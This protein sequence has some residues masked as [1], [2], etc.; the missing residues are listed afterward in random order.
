MREL[1]NQSY[2]VCVTACGAVFLGAVET[3]ALPE[4]RE[5]LQEMRLG[6]DLSL[7]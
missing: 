5:I 6:V 7:I 4:G 3:V 1:E 2:L